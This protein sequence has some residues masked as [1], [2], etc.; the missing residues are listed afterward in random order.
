MIPFTVQTRDE[1]LEVGCHVGTSTKKLHDAVSISASDKN[2]GFCVGIDNGPRIIDL[3][4]KSYGE[5][6]PFFVGDAWKTAQLN[7]FKQN[8]HM[9][10]LGYHSNSFGYDVIYVDIGGLSGPDGLLESLSLL[11][12]MGM[13]LEPRVIVIKSLCMR[14]LASSLRPFCEIWQMKN[15]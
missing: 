15:I 9:Q 8:E 3:A 13:S 2:K 5:S 4:K 14:R 11:N 7:S 12:S 6:V 10:E 1:V